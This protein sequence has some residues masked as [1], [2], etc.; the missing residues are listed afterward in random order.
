[1]VLLL[2]LVRHGEA[3]HP[4]EGGD[5]LRPLSDAGRETIGRL[6]GHYAREASRPGAIFSS[7][8]AR[9]RETADLLRAALPGLAPAV[10]DELVPDGE[11]ADVVAAL[12]AL[13]LPGHVILVGHQPLMGRLTAFLA[14]GREVG[15]LAGGLVR[16]EFHGALARGAGVIQLELPPSRTR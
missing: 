10:L 6:A 8:L 16:L 5:A 3:L 1:V 15:F 14:G 7:P 13:D 9:A 12:S 4:A 11:P 2:D